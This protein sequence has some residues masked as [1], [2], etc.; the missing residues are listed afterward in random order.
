MYQQQS[1]ISQN[2]NTFISQKFPNRSFCVTHQN[3]R[4]FIL[5]IAALLV[6][7]AIFFNPIFCS[8]AVCSS[9]VHN[10]ELFVLKVGYH[11]RWMN[12]S[13]SIYLFVC[14]FVCLSV[15]YSLSQKGFGWVFMK[16]SLQKDL[17][18]FWVILFLPWHPFSVF[19]KVK[20]SNH[21]ISTSN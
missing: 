10:V 13:A 18:K 9:L 4:I 21:F 17:I 12:V 8:G 11:L 19:V 1:V 14:L 5:H 3:D 20:T 7:M 2:Q 6:F 16:F 15:Y